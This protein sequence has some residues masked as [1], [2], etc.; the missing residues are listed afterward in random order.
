MILELDS[1]IRKIGALLEEGGWNK[2]TQNMWNETA[3]PIFMNF[4]Q[5]NKCSK[6]AK[7]VVHTVLDEIAQRMNTQRNTMSNIFHV[8]PRNTLGQHAIQLLLI[9][10]YT[11]NYCAMEVERL[12]SIELKCAV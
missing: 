11:V 8:E 5:R 9:P 1:H 7:H 2:A 10:S 12:M 3:L 6:T 4:V